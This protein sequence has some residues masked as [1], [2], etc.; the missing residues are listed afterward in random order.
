M[1]EYSML[2]SSISIPINSYQDQQSQLFAFARGSRP[3]IERERVR[4][5]R[6]HTCIGET[7][8]VPFTDWNASHSS[9][10]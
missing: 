9:N 7:Q 2:S 1:G 5:A 8:S 3:A 4:I 6:F 10:V